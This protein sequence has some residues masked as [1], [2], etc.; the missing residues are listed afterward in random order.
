MSPRGRRASAWRHARVESVAVRAPWSC[1][2]TPRLHEP[3]PAR[4]ETGH[5]HLDTPRTSALSLCHAADDLNRERDYSL[6]A[7]WSPRDG[8]CQLSP[9][10]DLP[11]ALREP[12]GKK[13]TAADSRD[14][15]RAWRTPGPKAFREKFVDELGKPTI[16]VGLASAAQR[17]HCLGLRKDWSG[18]SV[19]VA[20]Y[21][22]LLITE[23]FGLVIPRPPPPRAARDGRGT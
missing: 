8:G 10:A 18:R 5:T 3:G 21:R 17:A 2:A 9:C 6:G 20:E 16:A 23:A 7:S 11:Q 13:R 1:S 12:L 4:I 15:R 22:D 19:T 14:Y